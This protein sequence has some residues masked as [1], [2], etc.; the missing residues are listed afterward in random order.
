M[1]SGGSINAIVEICELLSLR[2]VEC[3]RTEVGSDEGVC[4]GRGAEP[5]F[6]DIKAKS[7][8]TGRK[9]CPSS[10]LSFIIELCEKEWYGFSADGVLVFTL[11][12][13]VVFGSIKLV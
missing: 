1:S 12:L 11:T 13:T 7:I 3:S 9:G 2:F 5:Y 6:S 10:N 8:T 4:F